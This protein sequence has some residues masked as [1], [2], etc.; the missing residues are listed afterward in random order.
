M[1][2]DTRAVLAPQYFP[3]HS[4]TGLAGG[5]LVAMQQQLQH[6]PFN[7]SSYSAGNALLPFNNYI[8][9]QPLPHLIQHNSDKSRASLVIRNIHQGFVEESHNQS[10]S[11]KSEP[12]WTS[13]DSSITSVPKTSKTITMTHPT[14]GASKVTFSTNIDVL[15]KVIQ[16]KKDAEQSSS[17]VNESKPMVSTSPIIPHRYLPSHCNGI[18]EDKGKFILTHGI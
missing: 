9:Q 12:L 16:T 4:Y 11:I 1:S 18:Y 7:Y 6:N 13:N 5:N 17:L 14:S 2:Y 10:P 15:M 8:Q 3:G